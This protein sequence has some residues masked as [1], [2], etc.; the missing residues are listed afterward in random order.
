[1]QT[2]VMEW[3]TVSQFLERHRGKVSKN[4]VYSRIRDGF[5][6]PVRVGR[7]LIPADALD[8]LLSAAQREATEAE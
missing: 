5:L 3:L 2:A 7:I 4:T 1:M 6:T 8:R